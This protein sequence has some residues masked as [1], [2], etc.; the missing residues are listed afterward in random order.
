M[1][2]KFYSEISYM[3]GIILLAAGC[4]CM[5]KADF[6][7][8]MVVAPAYLIYLKLSQVWGSITFGMTEYLFQAF[9]LIIMALAVRRFKLSYLFSFFTAVLYGYTLNGM[10]SLVGLIGPVTA[11]VRVLLYAAGLVSCAAGV[12]CMLHTYL[13]PEVY[14]LIVR[15]VP[16]RFNLGLAK[17][18]TIYDCVSCLVSVLM[19][20]CFFGLWRFEGVKLGTVLCAL[21]NGFLIDRF[22]GF[23]DKRFTFRDMLPIRKY[24]DK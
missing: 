17:F 19:S 15:E 10:L 23:M 2:R 3:F 24:F 20:F 21:V 18:K 9:L 12:A 7:I 5:V 1:Q 16:K 8:S 22:S 4:A 13:A 14:E 6:G 11:A